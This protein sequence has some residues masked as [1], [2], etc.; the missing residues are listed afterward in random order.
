MAETDTS[1]SVDIYMRADESTLDRRQAVVTRLEAIQ[2][3][4]GIDRFT[5]RTWP[6]RVALAGPN[7]D[8][9]SVLERF[10]RWATNAGVDFAPT[11]DR[12]TY[13]RSFTDERGETIVL[14]TVAFAV[15]ERDELVEVV[16]HADATRLRTVDELLADLDDQEST[17]ADRR[18]VAD[19]PP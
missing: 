1:R 8:V 2:S 9:L 18:V 11:F 13:D 15:Y 12:H 16:P 19:N 4:G 6:R 3:S 10:D 7:D 14:P 17:A 5:V